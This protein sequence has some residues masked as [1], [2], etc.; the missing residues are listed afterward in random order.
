MGNFI[1]KAMFPTQLMLRSIGKTIIDTLFKDTDPIGKII[2]I[3]G[4]TLP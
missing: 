3:D 2:K 4:K 1:L